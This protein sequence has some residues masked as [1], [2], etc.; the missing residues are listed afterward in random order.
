MPKVT[1]LG[2]S[3]FQIEGGGATI[4]IDPFLTDNPNAAVSAD[5]VSCEYIVLT[6][7][8]ADHV[9]DT[10]AIAKRTGATVIAN[11]EIAG[12]AEK[13]G[14][15]T[16][17]MHI[18]GAHE[19]PFGRVKLTIAHHGSSFVDGAYGGNPAGVTLTIEG[20]KIHHAGDTA[21]THDMSFVGEEGIDLAMVP[22]GDNFTMGVEDAVRS[23][24]FLRPK[25]V[26]PI[27]YDTWPIIEADAAAFAAGAKAKGVTCHV[28][29]PG[30]HLEL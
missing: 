20:K 10:V 29:E 15:G 19:F 12:R 13:E 6:H 1:F 14:L 24:D 28:L 18:G 5:A 4:L 7:A 22:I 2:H 25:A 26:V 9:G 21:L 30:Q 27:H 3:A 17:P 23:L 11:F 8:H 16:H